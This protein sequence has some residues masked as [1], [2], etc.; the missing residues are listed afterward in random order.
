M[1][2]EEDHPRKRAAI[3]DWWG[4][5]RAENRLKAK[6]AVQA[7]NVPGWMADALTQRLG[8]E[9]VAASWADDPEGPANAPFRVSYEVAEIITAQ[10]D[11]IR[12]TLIGAEQTEHGTYLTPKTGSLD[13]PN[14]RGLLEIG[15]SDDNP[16]REAVLRLEGGER[17]GHVARVEFVGWTEAVRGLTGFAPP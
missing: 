13:E 10:V 17:D 9:V 1:S 12:V 6:A 2:T 15:P 5:L 7:G 8:V 11:P 4:T 14:W 3:E 16:D